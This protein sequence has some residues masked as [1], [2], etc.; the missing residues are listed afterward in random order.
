[1]KTIILAIIVSLCVNVAAFASGYYYSGYK[2]YSSMYNNMVS[3]TTTRDI[4]V[5]K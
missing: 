1:M 5:K 4:P 2:V 3:V